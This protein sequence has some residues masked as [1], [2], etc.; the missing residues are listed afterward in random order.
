MHSPDPLF[1]NLVIADARGRLLM[2]ERDEHAPHSPHAWALPGGAIEPGETPYAAAV[3]E[4]EEETGLTGIELTDVATTAGFHPAIGWY[5]FVTF[6]A[7]TDL[8][9]D[10][11]EC[12]EGRQ[13]VFREPEDIAGLDLTTS[14]ARVLP[15]ALAWSPYV[16]AHGSRGEPQRCFAGVILVDRRGWILLQ[17]RDEHPRIDPDKWGLAGGHVEP[18][19]SFETAA[20]RELEEETGVRLN[21]GDLELYGEFLV[22]HRHAYGTW[23]RMRVF[24]A[25]TALTDADIECHEG[26][27]IVF[28]DPEQA[29]DLDL[30]AAAAIILPAFVA[31]PRHRELAG[32]CP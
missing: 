9:D 5:E 25:A 28:V 22:D 16:E 4:L 13:M 8:A 3:R 19:E 20:H 21:R 17:E 23:D 7:L 31:S 10:D 26:R 2:Q 27:R 6:G 1:V 24:V 18:G 15:T 29:L 32:A 30:T 14:T 11:V 12:H